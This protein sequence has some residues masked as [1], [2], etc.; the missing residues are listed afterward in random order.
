MFGNR[1]YTGK[2]LDV[3][4]EEVINFI[5]LNNPDW[6]DFNESSIE[7]Q[8]TE[9]IAGVAD[10]LCYYLDNQALETFLTTARQSK[11]IKA[12]LSTMGYKVD[13]C[14]TA[15]GEVIVTP[16]AT[17]AG[18]ATERRRFI[19]PKYTVV[20][21]TIQNTPPYLT[22]EEVSFGRDD[23]SVEI[24]VIQGKY[25]EEK[26]LSTD[27]ARSFKYYLKS[28]ATIPISHVYIKD[29]NWERVEDAFV[30]VEGGQKYSV[31][32]DS[33]DKVYI[34]FTHNWR[35]YLPPGD[36]DSLIISY[37]DTMG[38]EGIIEDHVLSKL[39]GPIV[40]ID[41]GEEISA[42][43]SVEQKEATYG[44]FD[45][46]D[47]NLQKANGKN[48]IRTM[49]RIIL[50]N[51]FE[52]HI[53]K[54]PWIRDCV[55]YD[56]RKD[57]NVVPYPHI[58][59]G[60]VVTVDGTHVN[61]EQLKQ[62]T[63]DLQEK[64]VIMTTIEVLSATYVDK[65]LFVSISVN[66]DTT[67]KERVRQQVEDTLINRYGLQKFIENNS[68]SKLKFGIEIVKRDIE[69]EILRM[70]DAIYNVETNIEDFKIRDTE[71]LNFEKIE[72]RLV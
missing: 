47:W 39:K 59:K 63:A 4:R 42:T 9:I 57:R 7:M 25:H 65:E 3:I 15:M 28:E 31:H 48:F 32:V 54:Q 1:S 18:E 6:T 35:K 41:T 12:I 66:G 68:E 46:V 33:K 29:E 53:R 61:S 49:D 38:R 64:T 44:A 62:L 60:W 45:N 51:D 26:V 11:N 13:N 69:Q 67:Y 27:L 58:L 40:D 16:T 24:P 14:G 36:G 72:V 10:M 30:E 2:D 19:I 17:D 37:V 43:L 50:L 56:W 21:S 71:F 22:N 55:V 5:K 52:A 23:V 20:F 70:S 34:L 8:Y